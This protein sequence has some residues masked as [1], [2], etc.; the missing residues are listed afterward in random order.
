MKKTT[1][2]EKTNKVKSKE[3]LVG[4]SVGLDEVT[5]E[6]SPL[7]AELDPEIL[8]VFVKPKKNKSTV[9]NTDYIPELERGDTDEEFGTD[10]NSSF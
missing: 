7:V 5:P 3:L 10:T 9:D 4:A 8:K 1:A 2:K 6:E